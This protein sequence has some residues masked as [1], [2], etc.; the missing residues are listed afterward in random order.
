[1]DEDSRE[2]PI[3]EKAPFEQEKLYLAC[4]SMKKVRKKAGKAPL[5]AFFILGDFGAGDR[6]GRLPR[7]K[8]VFRKRQQKTEKTF[9]YPC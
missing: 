9:S 4:E 1:M 3:H 5:L 2:K 6:P 7:E 8:D